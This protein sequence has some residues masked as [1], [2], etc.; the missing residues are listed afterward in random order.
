[1]HI[2]RVVRKNATRRRGKTGAG[3]NQHGGSA[4]RPKRAAHPLQRGQRDLRLTRRGREARLSRQGNPKTEIAVL[5]SSTLDRKE[6]PQEDETNG[7]EWCCNPTKAKR[8][9]YP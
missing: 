6:D 1:M 8:N 5:C 4:E 7:K 2:T 3:Q 9:E